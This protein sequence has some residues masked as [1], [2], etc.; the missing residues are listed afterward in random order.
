MAA[1]SRHALSFPATMACT[2]LALATMLALSAC[3]GGGGNSS[4]SSAP[5]SG[6]TGTA[7]TPGVSTDTRPDM[8]KLAAS[9]QQ[10]RSGF[11]A[12]GVRYPDRQGSLSDEMKWVRS[13]V[14]ETYLWYREVPASVRAENYRTPVDYFEALKTPAI[15][16]SGRP[17]DQFRFTY[18]TAE[19]E[20]MSYSGVELGYGVS[21]SST[22]ENVYPR[23]WRVTMVE[24]GSPAASAGVVRGDT[25]VAVDGVSISDQSS[26]GIDVLN[27]GLFPQSAGASHRFTF[28]RNNGSTYTA[29]F[30]ARSLSVQPVQNVKV[31]DTPTGKVGYLLF[32]DHNAVAEGQLIAAINTLKAANVN[33]VVLDMRYNGGGY[34][35]LASELAYMIAGPGPTTGK[36]FERVIYNDKATPQQPLGFLA[37]AA[38]LP[39]PASVATTAG[40]VLPHLGL[41]RVTMLTSPGTCS[42]SESVINGLRGVD[43]EVNLIGG[44]TCGKPY[45]FTPQDNCGTTYFAVQFQG[46]NAKGFGDYADGFQPTC[47]VSDDLSRPLGDTQEGML[48]AALSYRSNGVCTASAQRFASG[49][50]AAPLRL[51][52]PVVKEAAILQ[53]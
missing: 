8:V 32:N 26:S 44:E 27:A 6:N 11:S 13:F 3:G 47:R 21:W 51:V 17:K 34:L 18:T 35:A 39:A 10:P 52:R 24:P 25:L 50:P 1:S 5:Q 45:G 14:D 16:A 22:G 42:A 33:D 46:V 12:A 9:C 28:N 37:S 41:R 43:V 36:V 4:T 53:R 49:T 7:V 20:A 23:V 48:S 15:T 2:P 30:A 31:I 29:S 40:T 38:G 19:W